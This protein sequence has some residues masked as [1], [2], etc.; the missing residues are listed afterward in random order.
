MYIFINVCIQMNVYKQMSTYMYIKAFLGSLGQCYWFAGPF[1][2]FL[3]HKMP[4]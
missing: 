3:I 2:P 1:Y 4:L